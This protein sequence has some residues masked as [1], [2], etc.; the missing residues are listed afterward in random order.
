MI[1]VFSDILV[2]QASS[3]RPQPQYSVADS[4]AEDFHRSPIRSSSKPLRLG[5]SPPPEQLSSDRAADNSQ[6]DQD[7]S[8][9]NSQVD[10][11]FHTNDNPQSSSTVAP[12][13]G[14]VFYNNRHDMEHDRRSLSFP[15]S[16]SEFDELADDDSNGPSTRS[17][18]V[19]HSTYDPSTS[20]LQRTF[21]ITLS[22]VRE[23]HKKRRSKVS[24]EQ[25]VTLED[26]YSRT[27]FPNT[28]QRM[29]L[30]SRLEMTERQVQIWCVTLECSI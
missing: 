29:Q 13:Q 8:S 12:S 2:L 22:P 24:N 16:D 20:T 14:I 3:S 15:R 11:S 5:F 28:E 7:S 27:G 9:G 21:S 26:V 19:A 10:Q 30:G 17:S 4:T 23:H 18:T 25:L 6:G 1:C